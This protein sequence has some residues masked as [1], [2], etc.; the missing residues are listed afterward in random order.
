MHTRGKPLETFERNNIYQIGN[1]HL[2]NAKHTFNKW[3]IY[4]WRG[5]N[6]GQFCG[7]PCALRHR[8]D[9]STTR[10]EAQCCTFYFISWLNNCCNRC[11]DNVFIPKWMFRL[12]CP[13]KPITHTWTYNSS[14]HVTHSMRHTALSLIKLGNQ[15]TK[16]GIAWYVPNHCISCLICQSWRHATHKGVKPSSNINMQQK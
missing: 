10:D 3:G 15:W 5:S 13:N 12:P 9:R 16:Q 7:R 8:V 11:K 1:D 2:I 6:W 14:N 4:V